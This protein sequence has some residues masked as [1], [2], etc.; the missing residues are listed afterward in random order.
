MEING[1]PLWEYYDGFVHQIHVEK[2]Q[3]KTTGDMKMEVFENGRNQGSRIQGCHS[4]ER[5][6]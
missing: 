6:R 3:I 2:P 1:R 4:H 5:E